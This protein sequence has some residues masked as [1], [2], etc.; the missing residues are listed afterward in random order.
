MMCLIKQFR[1]ANDLKFMCAAACLMLLLDAVGSRATAATV[2][3]APSAVPSLRDQHVMSWLQGKRSVLSSRAVILQRRINDHDRDCHQVRE[4]DVALRARCSDENH[5]LGVEYS[6]YNRDRTAY[7]RQ[8]H[9]AILL[10]ENWA[11]QEGVVN[12]AE[13]FVFRATAIGL[14]TLRE[15]QVFASLAVGM[16]GYFRAAQAEELSSVGLWAASRGLVLEGLAAGGVGLVVWI[17][18]IAAHYPDCSFSDD[19]LETQCNQINVFFD[20]IKDINKNIADYETEVF[21][22]GH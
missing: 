6:D 19:Q 21:E 13:A 1:F 16:R 8:R 9:A 3:A 11:A 12:S 7:E 18:W 4:S 10:D 14:N 2:A 5:V 20:R 22:L 15:Y 17:D